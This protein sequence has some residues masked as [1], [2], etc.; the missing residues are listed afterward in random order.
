MSIVNPQ[1]PLPMFAG[2]ATP[3]DPRMANL[4]EHIN[5]ERDRMRHGQTAIEGYKADVASRAGAEKRVATHRRQYAGTRERKVHPWPGAANIHVPM[6]LKA[7][8]NNTSR[9]TEHGLPETGYVV[10]RAAPYALQAAERCEKAMNYQLMEESP[11]YYLGFDRGLTQMGI[12]GWLVRKVSWDFETECPVVDSLPWTDVVVSYTSPLPLDLSSRV[13]Q[14]LRMTVDDI[15]ERE[16]DGRFIGKVSELGPGNANST[17]EVTSKVRQTWERIKGLTKATPTR[18]PNEP[19][20]LME[21]YTRIRLNPNDEMS[22]PVIL[23]VDLESGVVVRIVTRQWMDEDDLD[24]REQPKKKTDFPFVPYLF[25]P[26]PDSPGAGYGLGHWLEG[27]GAGADTLVNSVLDLLT[28][29]NMPCGFVSDR[30]PMPKGGLSFKPGEWKPFDGSVEDLQ[31]AIYTLNFGDPSPV[32][33]QMLQFFEHWEEGVSS[34]VGPMT[35]ENPPINQ[36]ATT[37]MG[38]LEQGGKVIAAAGRRTLKSKAKEDRKVF[39]LNRRFLSNRKYNDILGNCDDDAW[40]Q[41]AAQAQA[42]HAGDPSAMQGMAQFPYDVKRDFSLQHAV[43]PAAEPQLFSRQERVAKSREVLQLT[44]Q[45]PSTAQDPV[46]IR[47]AAIEVMK[48]LGVTEPERFLPP[49]PPPQP[50]PDIPALKEN[51]MIMRGQY[52]APLPGQNHDQHLIAHKMLVTENEGKFYATM[53]TEQKQ[54]LDQHIREHTAFEYEALHHILEATP[55][56]GLP[57][58]NGSGPMGPGPVSPP[59]GAGPYGATGAPYLSGGPMAEVPPGQGA[60]GLPAGPP[61]Q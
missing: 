42:A 26:D 56:G 3:A 46:A 11:D 9:M 18:D 34:L 28:L 52:P 27:I 38:I 24:S 7:V 45:N 25:S 59:N 49:I 58:S 5:D 14:V 15:L 1:M 8:Q 47:E 23:T 4:A 2:G 35:G 40:K 32:A 51:A 43:R 37:T 22:T 50:P 30:S 55:N 53:T 48:E 21:Q 60:P 61:G 31:K 12:D 6:L 29:R 41:W 36:P 39:E 33:H 17:A 13:T 19:R 44:A 54:M 16:K 10:V 57:A 20:I